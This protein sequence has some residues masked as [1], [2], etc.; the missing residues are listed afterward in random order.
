MQIQFEV[1]NTKAANWPLRIGAALGGFL[2]LWAVS[3]WL[4]S[5]RRT[6]G[7]VV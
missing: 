1:A 5:G 7:V 2:L 6:T 4:L 3:A